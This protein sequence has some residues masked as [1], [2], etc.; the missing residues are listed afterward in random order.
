MTHIILRTNFFFFIYIFLQYTKYRTLRF[1]LLKYHFTCRFCIYLCKTFLLQYL[2]L[3]KPY[4]WS[5]LWSKNLTGMW[6]RVLRRQT[7]W[8]C[9]DYFHFISDN[10]FQVRFQVRL[11][12]KEEHSW[13]GTCSQKAPAMQG[14]LHDKNLTSTR[15]NTHFINSFMKLLLVFDSMMTVRTLC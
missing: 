4:L 2:D 10:R 12:F 7:C 6:R 15:S 13:V 14:I 5:N 3:V 8:E 9:L 11:R 1:A